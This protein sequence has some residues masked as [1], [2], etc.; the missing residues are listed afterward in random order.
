MA[1]KSLSKV[2][3]NVTKTRTP[4]CKEIEASLALNN[5]SWT[6]L[7]NYCGMP[8]SYI[9][10]IKNG[11]IP[12]PEAT[13]KIAHFFSRDWFDFWVI[14]GHMKK[15]DVARLQRTAFNYKWRLSSEEA[16]LIA[17]FRETDVLCSNYIRSAAR[18]AARAS[19]NIRNN[20][21][22][23]RQH[24]TYALV[25][26]E[27]VNRPSWLDSEK[28]VYETLIR[29]GEK[30]DVVVFNDQN[31]FNYLAQSTFVG[32]VRFAMTDTMSP[33]PNSTL[34]QLD[35]RHPD[36]EFAEPNTSA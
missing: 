31:G 26:L 35:E 28:I 14:A 22:H 12:S 19:E 5:M 36:D 10:R 18:G 33:M 1:V 15:E 2:N 30:I 20:P 29:D 6:K 25:E 11:W 7:V 32:T 4:L 23:I 9:S 34:F 21:E 13:T 3:K 24:K 27:T 17:A 16:E 8:K